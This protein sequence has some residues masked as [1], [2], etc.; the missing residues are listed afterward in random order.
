MTHWLDISPLSFSTLLLLERV[1]L[2][3]FPGWNWT[4][5]ADLAIALRANPAVAWYLRHKCPE[6][7]GWVD[8]LLA[9]HPAQPAD[10]ADVRRAE[11][12]VLGDLDDL[13]TYAVDPAAYDAQPFLGWDSTELTALVDFAGKT[14]IDVG[15]GTGRL[16]LLAAEAGAAAVFA[17]E[18][19]AN[20]RRY[21]KER[22]RARGLRNVFPVDGLITDLPFPDAFADVVMGGHVFGDEPEAEYAE[23]ARVVRPGGMIIL[24]P[25][26]GDRDDARHA[27]LIAAG[28]RWSRFEE[29]G[30]GMKRKYWK[31]CE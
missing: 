13:L 31:V 25:G 23:L 24:C 1:Q 16:A 2:N 30:D 9:D 11:V 22:A 4:A 10:P 26:N 17:A 14:V 3:W 21:L 19:V 12:L 6:I 5:P 8:G 28:F 15:A 18:P 7:A 29:P 20:L 27:F